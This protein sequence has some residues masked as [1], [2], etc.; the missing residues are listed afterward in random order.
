[1]DFRRRQGVATDT[2]KKSQNTI[3]RGNTTATVTTKK[4][5]K[6]P[7]TQHCGAKQQKEM[8]GLFTQPMLVDFPVQLHQMNQ[9][10]E[11]V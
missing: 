11:K 9:E 7:L 4:Q 3:H 8:C 5:H 6:A 2:N 10:L 1:M